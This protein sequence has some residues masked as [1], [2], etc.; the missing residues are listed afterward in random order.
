MK[1]TVC[2]RILTLLMSSLLSAAAFSLTAAAD[3]TENPEPKNRGKA[4][5]Y[6]Q[7]TDTDDDA[8]LLAIGFEPA[9]L[10]YLK[11]GEDVTYGIRYATDNP[12]TYGDLDAESD[13]K[14]KIDAFYN[15][16]GIEPEDSLLTAYYAERKRGSDAAEVLEGVTGVSGKVALGLLEEQGNV[17][18]F[19]NNGT[20]TMLYLAGEQAVQTE[21]TVTPNENGYVVIDFKYLGS[22]DYIVLYDTAESAE[23]TT[24]AAAAV[25]TSTT[26]ASAVKPSVTQSAPKT[27]DAGTGLLWA[28]GIGVL[29]SVFAAGYVKK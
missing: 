26:A 5:W 23:T 1:Y 8:A 18:E 14:R 2:S 3:N 29:I 15:A 9:D 13:T 27:G 25:T 16:E 10:E 4:S 6:G 24:T 22:G 19:V 11:N 21:T 12:R 17:Y 28:A 7:V 20:F